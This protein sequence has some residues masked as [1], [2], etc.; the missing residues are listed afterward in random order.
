M[1]N[2]VATPYSGPHIADGVNRDWAFTFSI[3]AA[4]EM[5]L[6]IEDT[7][8]TISFV[9]SG[10]S[11]PAEDLMDDTGGTITYPIAPVAELLVGV[12]VTPYRE[13]PYRQP[14][15][16]GR[17]GAFFP[18]VIENTADLLSRQ[19]Q[20]LR[21]FTM[22]KPLSAVA[23]DRASKYAQYS[24]DGLSFI[25]S[26]GPGLY[27]VS[28]TPVASLGAE[29]SWAISDGRYMWQKQSGV[30][31]NTGMDLKGIQGDK[32]DPGLSGD[33]SGDMVAAANLS[34]LVSIATA[35]VNLGLG[36]VTNTA[37]A[38]KPISTAAAAKHVTQD[39]AIALNTAK[40]TYP[41]GDSTK[42]SNIEANAKNNAGKHMLPFDAAAMR[43][44]LTN[45]AEFGF[46]ET[47][48]N[49]IVID[50][51]KFDAA[52]PEYVQFKFMLPKSYNDGTISA[53]FTWAP[54]TATSGDVIWR[55]QAV[56]LADGEAL[57][58]GW[59]GAVSVTDTCPD[60]AMKQAISP[61]SGDVTIAGAAA[62]EMCYVRIS[63]NASD[64]GDTM[65]GDALLLGVELFL[66]TDAGTDA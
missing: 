31:V 55:I 1:V 16:L 61:E 65:T 40:V 29:S 64:V 33:G 44:Q 21:H 12:K 24:T 35:L 50:Y 60:T 51:F 56:S 20:Q 4:A 19:I 57:D 6:Q 8:G 15:P 32:G 2:P 49:D 9:S 34:D 59:G 18:K 23:A 52:T 58:A 13:V 28:G 43:G 53:R 63:R 3:Q 48:T 26:D 36:N 30:W 41:S 45:G 39:A 66:T 7:D 54:E 38:D 10:F 37:D 47:V 27:A 5:R 62:E 46:E 11:I 17:E 22:G 25:L 14:N 42:L